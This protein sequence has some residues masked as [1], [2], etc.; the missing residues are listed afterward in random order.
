MS[1]GHHQLD[2]WFSIDSSHQ[3]L[4]ATNVYAVGVYRL[5]VR[6]YLEARFTLG[7]G[8]S[9]RNFDTWA[10]RAGSVGPYV[11][12]SPLGIAIRAGS[13]VRFI[14]DPGEIA[15]P[16]PQTTGIPLIY[17]QHRF[18]FGVQTNF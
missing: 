12:V 16:I 2:P 13:H 10:A 7:V 18:S 1:S 6:D 5:D 9:V 3:V 4:G 15:I 14:V 8:I 11:A 17:R